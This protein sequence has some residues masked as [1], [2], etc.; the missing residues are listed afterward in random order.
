MRR[1]LPFDYPRRN[2]EEIEIERDV[3]A[4][5]FYRREIFRVPVLKHRHNT[6]QRRGRDNKFQLVDC[7]G[8]RAFYYRK[9][10][11]IRRRDKNI[12]ALNIE[13]TAGKNR[14]RV[15]FLRAGK[16]SSADSIFQHGRRNSKRL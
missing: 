11:S 2:R 6:F 16:N 13:T 15:I 8:Y 5:I 7:V 9:P 12:V 3:L 1:E 14:T 4:G 10:V